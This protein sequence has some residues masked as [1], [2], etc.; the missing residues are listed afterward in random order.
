[1]KSDLKGTAL[2]KAVEAI[3]GIIVKAF[4]GY[5]EKNF[6]IERRKVLIIAGVRH[7]FDIWVE[8]DL[9]NGYRSIF[10]F[11]CKNR[12]KK[13]DKNDIMI[14]SGKASAVSAQAAYFVAKG[15]TRDARLQAKLDPRMTLL[16]ARDLPTAEK[17]DWLTTYNLEF[18]FINRKKVGI[19]VGVA[20]TP[21]R[22]KFSLQEAVATLGGSPLDLAA[23][24]AAWL[25]AVCDT[26]T[27]KLGPDLPDGQYPAIL[28]DVR[29]YNPGELVIDGEP[30]SR[31][32]IRVELDVY[33]ASAHILSAFEVTGRGRALLLAPFEFPGGRME[34][35]AVDA[36]DGDAG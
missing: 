30:I 6:R 3:E 22:D 12:T 27:Q 36:Q 28:E 2:E 11:E 35:V 25:D 13:A 16:L 5:N 1:M 19:T 32:R 8:V 29:R 21:T 31:I 18:A 33:R 4:P 7:E 9:G 34:M 17:D 14:L 26:H 20:G 23:Y 10:V 15:Y 24:S